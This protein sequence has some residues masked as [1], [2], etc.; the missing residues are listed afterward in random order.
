MYAE[1]ADPSL[2]N[3]A[4]TAATKP[5]ISNDRDSYTEDN[6]NNNHKYMYIHVWSIN[7]YCINN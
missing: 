5:L 2:L 7:S 6:D 1:I 3:G 4:N